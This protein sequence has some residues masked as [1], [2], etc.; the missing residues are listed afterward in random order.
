MRQKKGPNGRPKTV[1]RRDSGSGHL[2]D[3]NEMAIHMRLSAQYGFAWLFAIIIIIIG[4]SKTESKVVCYILHVL[5]LIFNVLNGATGLFIFFAFICNKRILHLYKTRFRRASR[6][7]RS[8]ASTFTISASQMTGVMPPDS[9][10]G[11]SP[12]IGPLDGNNN[13]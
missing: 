6:S 7:T 11:L 13:G 4:T 2:K 5:N 9:P 3:R 10:S 8:F 12:P 1:L